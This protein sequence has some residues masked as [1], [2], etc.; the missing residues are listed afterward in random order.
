[1]KNL[2]LLLIFALLSPPVYGSAPLCQFLLQSSYDFETSVQVFTQRLG[3]EVG[4]EL[5]R[6]LQEL[7]EMAV[8]KNRGWIAKNPLRWRFLFSNFEMAKDLSGKTQIFFPAQK[9]GSPKELRRFDDTMIELVA[10]YRVLK[11]PA[12]QAFWSRLGVSKGT[13]LALLTERAQL[14]LLLT[15]QNLFRPRWDISLSKLF[16]LNWPIAGNV[17]LTPE[18]VQIYD[19]Q[20]MTGFQERIAQK[21]GWRVSYEIKLRVTERILITTVLSSLAYALYLL[22]QS[23]AYFDDV[24]NL[25]TNLEGDDLATFRKILDESAFK[26]R[27][28][29]IDWG[30]QNIQDPALK[31]FFGQLKSELNKP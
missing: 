4:P 6:D 27:A 12:Y 19:S 3:P 5:V 7:Q 10:R 26:D 17:K 8:H 28:D 21:Y 11:S 20:G 2:A 24:L 30:E 25:E 13:K 23:D 9:V 31:E 29:I 16:P 22:N 15:K 1:M 14:Q 18:L